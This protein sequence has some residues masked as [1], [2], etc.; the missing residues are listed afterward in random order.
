MVEKE[1]F[2]RFLRAVLGLFT[3]GWLLAAVVAPPDP[4]TFLLLLV[5]TWVAG[6]AAAVWL[7]YRGGY[8][9]LVDSPLYRPRAPA[10]WATGGFVALA[11]AL[12]LAFTFAADLLLGAAA[13]GLAEGVV[14]GVLAVAVAYAAVF[15]AGLLGVVFDRTAEPPG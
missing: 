14:A 10:A 1:R 15:V 12:K 6:T 13:V 2:G 3:V 8:G 9:T 5:A 11:I 4:F 7:V